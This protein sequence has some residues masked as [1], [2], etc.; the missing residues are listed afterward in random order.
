[1]AAAS[2]LEGTGAARAGGVVV[3]A[4]FSAPIP[5]DEAIMAA[6][7]LAG[8]RTGMLLVT[9]DDGYSA[10]VSSR[11]TDSWIGAATPS[12]F[13]LCRTA[14]SGIFIFIIF[15]Y[16]VATASSSLVSEETFPPLAELPRDFETGAGRGAAGA[17]PLKTES[18]IFCETPSLTILCRIAPSGIF[19]LIIFRYCSAM[20]SSSGD[21]DDALAALP[22]EAAV[23]SGGAAFGESPAKTDSWIF[24]ETPSLTILCRI[25]PSGILIFIIFRYCSAMASSSGDRTD[26]ARSLR[27]PDDDGL[28][29][30][31]GGSPPPDMTAFTMRSE[32]PSRA[33]LCPTAPSGM[34]I[35]IIFRYFR[36][37]SSSF[38]LRDDPPP[39]AAPGAAL[40]GGGGLGP[41]ILAASAAAAAFLDA[42][43]AALS[44]WDTTG[45][46]FLGVCLVPFFDF[47]P[48][49]GSPPY[50][51]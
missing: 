38:S 5:P 15:R 8:G 30:P 22:V 40:A 29:D 41:P 39:E 20:A 47:V 34:P 11:M 43:R 26:A 13:I 48:F 23:L 1:M 19:I 24:C 45:P 14:P 42:L 31:L 10:G 33:I 4:F 46:F 44:A 3:G 2:G 12:L 25:A 32:T 50:T 27:P 35:F 21:R 18:W 36:T 7:G 28:D 6:I 51:F 9:A 16:G 37:V 17:S 49:W